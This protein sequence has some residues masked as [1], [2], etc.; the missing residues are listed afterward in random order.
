MGSCFSSSPSSTAS[1]TNIRP[2]TA[3]VINIDGSLIE[4]SRPVKVSQVLGQNQTSSFL[5]NADGIFYGQFVQ[6]LHPDRLIEPAQLYFVLPAAKLEYRLTVADMVALAVSASSAFAAAG[7]VKTARSGGRNRR[8]RSAVEVMP[9]I[10]KMDFDCYRRI[11][12]VSVGS[13]RYDLGEKKSF[14]F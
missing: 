5:C 11:S 8:R 13:W 2:S 6:A 12:E 3:K 7:S 9:I 10:E 4:F 14:G 1:S